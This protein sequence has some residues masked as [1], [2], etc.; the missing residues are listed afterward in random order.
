[1]SARVA[2]AK[3]HAAPEAV[4]AVARPTLSPAH[5]LTLHRKCACGGDAGHG[6]S[7]ESCA[8]KQTP[9]Q[10]RG[11]G[12]GGGG[13]PSSVHQT[14]SQPGR[15]LD[16][17][18][19][20]LMESRFGEDFSGVR[21]HDDNTAAQSAR[22]V[23]AHAYTVGESIVFAPG[24]YQPHSETG[25][26]L[27]AHE[28]AHTV[29]QKGLQRSGISS[30]ADQGPEYRRLEAEADRAADFAMRGGGTFSHGLN[31]ASRP[32]LSRQKAEATGDEATGTE[33]DVTVQT[34][35]LGSHTHKVK[36][37][38]GYERDTK[39]LQAFEVDPLLVP[40]SKGPNAQA[41][42][43]EI[44][45]GALG[46]TVAISDRAQAPLW[47]KPRCGRAARKLRTFAAAGCRR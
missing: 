25:Q 33:V 6:A 38:G 24:Q 18:T 28:L 43:Q 1:M 36:A 46:A 37:V 26:H 15:P 10:R 41:R 13:I 29:Q 30:L 32:T 5:G 27:L 2:E 23:H 44:A 11:D 21:V 16:A 22:D 9:L 35:Q 17:G 3:S 7:C 14:L 47:A 39:T 4:P 40:K 8:S 34:T 12:G 19:R 20:S 31:A 45:G 42:Y